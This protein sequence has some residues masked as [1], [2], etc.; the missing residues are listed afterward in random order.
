MDAIDT[1]KT[2]ITA[3][4]SG[5]MN[6]A[7]DT[8]ADDFTERGLT[9]QTLDK[10]AFLALQSALLAA[11]PNFSY[12]LTDVREEDGKVIAHIRISGTQLNELV[13]PPVLGVPTIAPTG[14]D[15]DLPQVAATYTVV[16]EK[17]AAM[18][19][20][21]VAGGGLDG[22]LQQVGTELPLQPRI[23]DIAD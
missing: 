21:S 13:L 5:D 2:L 17:V 22:L 3:L 11:M 7:A 20:E 18:L 10:S 15:V 16:G 23:R 14:L 1:V 19:V 4:Q 6:L 8:L 9:A 12:N